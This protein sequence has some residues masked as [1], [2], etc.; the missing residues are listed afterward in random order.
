MKSKVLTWWTV[1]GVLLVLALGVSP[2]LAGQGAG[3]FAR[4]LAL[5]A[6]IAALGWGYLGMWRW[7]DRRWV[8]GIAGVVGG[9]N[10]AA[11]VVWGLWTSGSQG[12]AIG[13][14]GIWVMGLSFALGLVLIRLVL[15]GS[16]PI[17]GVARTLVDEAVRM[18]VALVFI[19]G[20]AILVP[21]LPLLM[22]PRE[23]LNYRIKTFLSWSIAGTGVLLSLMTVF[24][25]AGTICNEIRQKQI[26]LT[27]SK[28]LGRGQYLAGKW[29]GI[30]LLNLWLL[31]AAGGGIYVFAKVLQAQPA[32]DRVD[33]AAVDFEVL[34]ARR[35]VQA[36]MPSTMNYQELFKQRLE[37]LRRENPERFGTN[38]APKDLSQGDVTAIRSV[39][40][41]RWYTVP[42][43][44]SQTY[45]FDGLQ[46]TREA[47][48]PLQLRMKPRAAEP[49]PD[50]KVK[51]AL[52]IHGRPWPLTPEGMPM[53][54]DV[55]HDQ[56]STIPL[57]AHLINDQGV[58]ELTIAHVNLMDPRATPSTSISFTPGEGLELLYRVGGF[59]GNLVRAL[60][61][62]W[63][64]LAFLAMLGL[65]AG[66]F[67]GF[68]VACL[69]CLLVYL[70]GSG[71]SFLGEAVSGFGGT[72]PQGA[73]W[74]DKI[75]WWPTAWMGHLMQGKWADA[76]K[77]I[78]GGLGQLVLLAMPSLGRFS[79]SALL[80]DGRVISGELVGK[81]SL[82]LGVF[83]CGITGVIG[84]F[85]LKRR[86][87]A[88]A[89]Q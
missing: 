17:I 72:A 23:L 31:S 84:W 38:Q 78:I 76:F 41:T 51:L 71:S 85:I 45:V 3:T 32:T 88:T 34:A 7:R 60:A 22:D 44:G 64:Q 75:A 12:K 73:G 69:L 2:L 25:A 36:S 61:L 62:I 29:L 18:K 86:E 77:M 58:L 11:L 13:L 57:P 56:Y 67:L 49:P 59:E 5:G 1:L 15:S 26:Y 16:H 79:A 63:W 70:V 65:A 46:A 27:L 55:V 35:T 89:T 8:K 52:A 21:I 53:Q 54:M 42:P 33:R 4:M 81:A 47:G 19:V 6:G 28:P 66:T 40:L 48:I 82:S 43:M 10:L 37:Q 14:A 24:L 9:S 50:G 20:V 39:I 30:V 80:A 68:P 83:G 74:W 87:L